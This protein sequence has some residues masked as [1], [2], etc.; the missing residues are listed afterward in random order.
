[1]A[2]L[3]QVL[4]GIRCAT[5]AAAAAYLGRTGKLALVISMAQM[6][7]GHHVK[8]EMCGPGL[9]GER[10]WLHSPGLSGH[11]PFEPL[12]HSWSAGHYGL[13]QEAK[14]H[15]AQVGEGLAAHSGT[16]RSPA[17]AVWHSSVASHAVTYQQS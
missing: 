15:L 1:M 13:Q 10:G 7:A 6:I 5:V 16:G 9:G 4:H 2:L 8:M 3:A 11:M 17:L 14:P 12:Q